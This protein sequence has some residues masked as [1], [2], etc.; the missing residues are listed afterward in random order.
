MHFGRVFIFGAVAGNSSPNNESWDLI[1]VYAS[2][3]LRAFVSQTLDCCLKYT[4]VNKT[5]RKQVKALQTITTEGLA[6]R[7]KTS[8]FTCP[9]MEYKNGYTPIGVGLTI[10][11]ELTC[12]DKDVKYVKP[13][14]PQLETTTKLAIH[15]QVAFG[16]IPAELIIEWMETYLYLGV[17]KV[18]TYYFTDINRNALRTLQYYANSGAMKLHKY[19]PAQSGRFLLSI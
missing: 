4:F 19:I 6:G 9:N 16:N 14:Y 18:I 17:D 8:H 7:L 5:V 13:V 10:S 1:K 12:Q 2:T 11:N 3:D 15:T